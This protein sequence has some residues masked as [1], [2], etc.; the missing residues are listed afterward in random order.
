MVPMGQRWHYADAWSTECRHL[1]KG[2]QRDGHGGATPELGVDG[3]VPAVAAHDPVDDDQ[4]DP[5]AG[6]VERKNSLK[7]PRWSSSEIPSPW[8]TTLR[9][10]WSCPASRR[11]STREPASEYFTALPSRLTS[12]RCS[13]S[14]RPST[15]TTSVGSVVETAT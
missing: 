15:S 9:T 11:T 3:D 14:G 10:T 4:D 13:S 5:S 2:W 6:L 12:I 8:S 7:R 1:P